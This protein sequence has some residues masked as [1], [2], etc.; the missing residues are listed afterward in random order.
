MSIAVS[1]RIW[2]HF[3]KGGHELLAML[4][5]AEWSDDDGNCWPAMS[6]IAERL[7]VTR[8]QAQRV[9]R[10]LEVQGFVAV[11]GNVNGGPPG[12]TRRYRLQLD[13]L[14]GRT[15]A[16]PTGR[17]DATGSTDAT[18]RTDAGEGPHACAK[19][20]RT[21]AAL[22]VIE[23]SR[24]VRDSENPAPRV[25][26]AVVECPHQEIISLF[27]QCLPAARQ[28]REWTTARSQT[29]RTRWRE[30][31]ERQSLDW[32]RKFFT[33]VG[34]SDFLMGRTNS[35]GRQPF[36]VSLDWLIKPENMARVIEGKY[37]HSTEQ[38]VCT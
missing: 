32:W 17:V 22:T 24:T 8:S 16:A 38:E 37:H 1:T 25:P 10:S 5:L 29:L 12:S 20:G 30:K 34:Q 14:T 33:Y 2:E 27:A 19:R 23:P 3:P 13:R 35:P 36:E 21:H 4:A 11:T 18:G 9:V 15:D 7:R 31:R 28:V 26:A 6:S